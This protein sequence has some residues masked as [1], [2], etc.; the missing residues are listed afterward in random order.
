MD[1]GT[2][3]KAESGQTAKAEPDDDDDGVKA[4]DMT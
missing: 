1:G 4:E 3:V 2:Q